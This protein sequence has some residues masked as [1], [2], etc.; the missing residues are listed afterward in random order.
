MRIVRGPGS[1][2]VNL[3]NLG[4]T[5]IKLKSHINAIINNSQLLLAPDASYTTGSF[6]GKIWERSDVFYT[7]QAMMSQSRFIPELDKL[8]VAFFKYALDTWE[9]FT[10]EFTVGE[11]D[12]TRA[13]EMNEDQDQHYT[14]YRL[15]AEYQSSILD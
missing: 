9:R 8:L 3:L 14:S 12:I 4:P 2:R 5:F 10:A 7:I 1:E 13:L 11:G 6:D 15:S